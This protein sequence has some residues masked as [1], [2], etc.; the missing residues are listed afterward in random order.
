MHLNGCCVKRVGKAN[1]A[2]IQI[3]ANIRCATLF[4]L[5]PVVGVSKVHPCPLGDE[6]VS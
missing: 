4:A 1:L 5:L 3:V 2:D 6:K